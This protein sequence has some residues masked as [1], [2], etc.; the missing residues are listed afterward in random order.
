[1][2][3]RVTVRPALGQPVLELGRVQP[4][5]G[6]GIKAHSLPADVQEKVTAGELAPATAY[7]VSRIEDPEQQR[8][9]AAKVVQ[10]GLSRAEAVEHVRRVARAP[11]KGRGAAKAVPLPKPRTFRVSGGK[12]ILEPKK[13]GGTEA[14]LAIAREVVQVLETELGARTQDAA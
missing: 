13:V 7:E 4:D 6:I 14:L 3:L 8:E 10:E 11:K 2:I 1:M 12:A 9:V 5:L